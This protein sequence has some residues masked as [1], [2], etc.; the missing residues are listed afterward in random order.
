MGPEGRIMTQ[1]DEGRLRAWLDGELTPGEGAEIEA[2]LEENPDVREKLARLRRREEVVGRAL[3]AMDPTPPTERVRRRL[4]LSS[5]IEAASGTGHRSPQ[6]ATAGWWARRSR[7]A[8]AA[9]FLALL[10]GGASAALPGSPVRDW[11]EQLVTK[12]GPTTPTAVADEAAA[13]DERVGARIAPADGA[14]ELELVGLPPGTE[15]EVMLVES[16]RASVTAPRGARFSTAAGRLTATVP[17]GPVRVEIP[18]SVRAILRVN[19]RMFLEKTGD[20]LT[21]R[22]PVTDRTPAQLRF[23]VEG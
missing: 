12:A 11:M 16:G 10:A 18:T 2:W 6:A 8:Q 17:G 22:G 4:G 13:D 15:I 9:L 23:R 7:V 21:L 19:E 3:E 1:L 20:G 14:V 5:R